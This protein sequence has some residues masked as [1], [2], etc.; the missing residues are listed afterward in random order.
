MKPNAE[1]AQKLMN[2]ATR[3][4]MAGDVERYLHALRLLFALRM[5]PVAMA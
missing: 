2:A 1:R 3:M 5:R 4:M